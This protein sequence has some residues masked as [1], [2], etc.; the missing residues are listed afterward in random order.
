M[1]RFILYSLVIATVLIPILLARRGRPARSLRRTVIAMSAFIATWA[2]TV[3]VI[4]PR[5]L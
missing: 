5:I 4:V 3:W 1:V 2:F